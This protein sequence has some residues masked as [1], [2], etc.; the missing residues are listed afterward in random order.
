MASPPSPP[1]GI[2]CPDYAAAKGARRCRH[3][4]DGGGC[5][6]ASHDECVEWRKA[7]PGRPAPAKVAAAD[8]P[9]VERDLFGEPLPP[10]QAPRRPSPGPLAEPEPGR[11]PR[12]DDA[13][14]RAPVITEADVESFRA[15]GAEVCLLS[16]ELGEVW[17]VPEPTAEDRCELLPEQLALLVHATAAFPGS[18]V[19]AFQRRASTPA[20]VPAAQGDPPASPEVSA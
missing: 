2:T 14:A 20:P 10:P 4:Q 8:G 19:V 12:A 6:L 18:R 3:F 13:P 17:I 5:A 7:N 16:P 15:L 1:P 9:G 11:A